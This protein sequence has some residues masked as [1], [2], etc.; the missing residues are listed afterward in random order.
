MSPTS[1]RTFTLAASNPVRRETNG[2]CGPLDSEDASVR[3][4]QSARKHCDVAGATTYVQHMHASTDAGSEKQLF[5]LGFDQR[6]LLGES[7][8]LA[9]R[10]AEHV[11]VVC[12]PGPKPDREP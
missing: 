3:A 11:C 7:L 1:K 12:H 9:L 10:S 8:Q 6:G 4:N 5:R 2:I